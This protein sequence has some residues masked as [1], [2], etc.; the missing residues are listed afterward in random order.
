MMIVT[1]GT[2]NVLLGQALDLLHHLAAVRVL[3]SSH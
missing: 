1:A 3:S 2:F